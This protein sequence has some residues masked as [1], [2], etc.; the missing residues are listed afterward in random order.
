MTK[1][2]IK[3][4]SSTLVIGLFL[5]FAFGSGESKEEAK[6][7]CS[8][9]NDAYSNG[10]SSG[11]MCRQLNDYSS[12]ESFIEQYNNGVG[13]NVLVASECYCEG[14]NDGKNDKPKKYN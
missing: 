10:Y 1:K 9:Q 6:T 4:V 8:L 12:C 11:K 2:I 3:T 7:D 14:F 13:R 5:F